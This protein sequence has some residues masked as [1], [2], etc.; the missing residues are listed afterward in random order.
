M[1]GDFNAPDIKWSILSASAPSSTMLCDLIF[2]LNLTQLII[3]PTQINIENYINIETTLTYTNIENY[4]NNIS[5]NN[6]TSAL[7][8][9]HFIITFDIAAAYSFKKTTRYVLELILVNVT[10]MSLIVIFWTLMSH[11]ALLLTTSI[12]VGIHSSL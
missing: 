5:V 9:D 4:I 1:V 12:A 2:R 10:L 3:K 6:H 11:I 8:S 7:S